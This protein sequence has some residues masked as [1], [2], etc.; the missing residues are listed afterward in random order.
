MQFFKIISYV[1]SPPP[2]YLSAPA[3]FPGSHLFDPSS[4]YLGISSELRWAGLSSFIHSF[5]PALGCAIV[6]FS[7][8]QFSWAQ[9][10][11]GFGLVS[12]VFVAPFGF[13]R[14]GEGSGTL[15]AFAVRER[16]RG[17]WGTQ[18]HSRRQTTRRLVGWL[19]GWMAGWLDGW[20]AGSKVCGSRHA[21]T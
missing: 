1:N 7:S 17:I 4:Q 11:F 13:R 10:G 15:R 8:V 18:P 19:D 12:D 14:W 16:G 21:Y 6:Q 2:V 9:F 5:M 3:P 20:L